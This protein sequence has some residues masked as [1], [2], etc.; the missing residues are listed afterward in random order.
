MASLLNFALR[1]YETFGGPRTSLVSVAF[2]GALL[3]AL[4]LVGIWW[5]IG[6]Y[7]KDQVQ[8]TDVP[9][10]QP[11]ESPT[12]TAS[13]H[14]I[15]AGGNVVVIGITPE[16]YEAGLKRKEQEIRNELTQALPNDKG[17]LESRL[18]DTQAKLQ[19]RE[20][21]L[22]ELQSHARAGT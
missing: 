2:V 9:T 8:T 1:L 5:F 11:R 13:E 16:Q 12:A 17:K 3:G 15:A 14:S 10:Q 6:Q 20:A 7:A 4:I 19:N 18:D 22:E 21:A